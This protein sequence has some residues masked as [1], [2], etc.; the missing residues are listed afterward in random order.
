MSDKKNISSVLKSVTKPGRYIGGEYNRVMKN[1]E[2]VKCRFAFCF[3]DTYEIGMSNLGVRILYDVL[4]SDKDVWCERVYAPWDDMRAKMQE[5]DIPLSAVESGD[6]LTAFD[7]VA[8][9]LQYELCYTTALQMLKL[10]DI[11][12]WAKD[13]AEDCPIVIGGGPC[14]FNSEPIAEFFDL[15]NVGEGEEV[16]L[17]AAL[18][19]QLSTALSTVAFSSLI[20][21]RADEQAAFGLG[22]P[23]VM[24]LD[25]KVTQSFEDQAT[26]KVTYVDVDK[27]FTLYLGDV[28]DGGLCF[29]TVADSPLTCT[30]M[31]TVFGELIRSAVPSTSP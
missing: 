26:G 17:D 6:P 30:L 11:P 20:S 9:S 7:M 19:K 5:Y 18:G 31:G 14:V 12:V 25:Y 21:Y 27:S 16:L 28:S 1:K 10:A 13:R 2:E 22:D 24:T 8:F 4:N 29:A 15:I 3:P 23:W